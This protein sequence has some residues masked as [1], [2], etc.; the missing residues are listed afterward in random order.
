[1]SVESRYMDHHGTLNCADGDSKDN[2]SNYF[3]LCIV[4]YI[5]TLQFIYILD[6]IYIVKLYE[7]CAVYCSAKQKGCNCSLET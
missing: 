7:L 1:M 6:F 2:H 3:T 5:Y 4:L